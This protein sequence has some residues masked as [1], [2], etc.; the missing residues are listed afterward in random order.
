M[1]V[2]FGEIEW[3]GCS[4]SKSCIR[5]F[6]LLLF[7][8]PVWMGYSFSILIMLGDLNSPIVTFFGCEF[9]HVMCWKQSFRVFEMCGHIVIDEYVWWE[10]LEIFKGVKNIKESKMTF[11]ECTQK[12]KQYVTSSIP[13]SKITK[14]AVSRLLSLLLA[15]QFIQMLAFS[16]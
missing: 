2:I 14:N 12:F 1:G 16:L 11:Q 7:Y 9:W 8:R 6:D 4:I 3:L 5:H 10:F 15:M 13:S